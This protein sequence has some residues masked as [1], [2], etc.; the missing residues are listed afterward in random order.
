MNFWHF[1]QLNWSELLVL[2]AQHIKLVAVAIVI[3]VAIG[4]PT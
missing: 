3:G 4:V 2:I 1:L